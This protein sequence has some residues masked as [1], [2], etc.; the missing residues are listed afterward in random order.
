MS[1]WL[2]G[3]ALQRLGPHPHFSLWGYS[4]TTPLQGID[5]ASAW[6]LCLSRPPTSYRMVFNLVLFSFFL[7]PACGDGSTDWPH[8]APPHVD[9]RHAGSKEKKS[10][11]MSVGPLPI[12]EPTHNFEAAGSPSPKDV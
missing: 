2:V 7:F 3:P 11:Y 8:A 4:P 9:Q 12:M 1:G 6:P 5:P 10:V